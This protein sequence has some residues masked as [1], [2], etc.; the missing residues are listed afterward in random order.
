MGTA[1]V[2]PPCRV[3]PLVLLLIPVLLQRLTHRPLWVIILHRNGIVLCFIGLNQ[4]PHCSEGQSI[5]GVRILHF[6]GKIVLPK[7]RE[8]I[9]SSG[10]FNP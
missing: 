9:Y 2:G 7:K 3:I 1:H 10:C 6:E 4:F 8:N 5:Q